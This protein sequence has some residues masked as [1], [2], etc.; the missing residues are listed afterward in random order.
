MK[1][2][3]Q[4]VILNGNRKL[5]QDYKIGPLKNA[6]DSAVSVIKQLKQT[7]S[8]FEEDFQTDTTQQIRVQL[9]RSY[10]AQLEGYRQVYMSLLSVIK[11]NESLPLTKHP[12]NF[13]EMYALDS[14]L[15]ERK[16]KFTVL[17]SDSS[18]EKLGLDLVGDSF[19]VHGCVI[20]VNGGELKK[21]FTSAMREDV[22][23][24]MQLPV[25]SPD[26]IKLLI[27][28]LY[29]MPVVFKSNR[30][31]QE[32]YHIANRYNM[33]PLRELCRYRAMRQE[34][35]NFHPSK[36]P[37][38]ESFGF[39]GSVQ[40]MVSATDRARASLWRTYEMDLKPR[41]EATMRKGL[42]SS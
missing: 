25:S 8:S 38:L 20:E 7:I 36:L 3:V 2:R 30:E 18:V 1:D 31:A 11:L 27:Q 35:E 19:K 6:A 13:S 28:Y 42:P 33:E 10:Q 9:Q 32:L 34:L 21:A 26:V 41:F 16:Y 22:E 29:G 17:S 14:K 39:G 24:E 37:T 5:Y 23:R 15:S 40:E 4:L 12:F